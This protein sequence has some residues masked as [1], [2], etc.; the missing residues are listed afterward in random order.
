MHTWKRYIDDVLV[1][2]TGSDTEFEEFFNFLNSFHT[3]IK[4]DEPQHN[5]EDNSCEFLDLKISIKDGKIATDL[6]RKDTAKPRA[7]LP[8]SAH[9][10]HITSNIVYSMAFRLIRIC[11]TEE[12]FEKR[13]E[14]LKNDFLIPRQYTSKVIESQFKRIRNLPGNDYLE[15]RKKTLEKKEKK[16][17]ETNRIVAPMDFNPVLPKI[18]EI[19]TKHHKSMIFKKPELKEVFA[20]PPMA[21]MRQPPNIRK[22]ICR[23]ALSQPKRAD[24]LGRKTHKSAPGW[25]K[26][27]QGSTTCCPFALP[28]TQTVVGQVTGYS[29]EIRDPVTCQTQ[30]CVY[31]WKCQKE[32]CK[33]Y[34]RCEYVGL[35]SRPYR[36]RL[37]EHKQYVRSRN[38][39]TPSG[40]HF[41][42]QGHT[43]SHLGG[44][45]LEHVK[46]SDPFVLR[47]REFL[48]IQKFDTFRNGLN[49]EH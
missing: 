30:N 20:E 22:L 48:Y 1:I 17:N 6:Y 41:N 42:Q 12:N 15:R 10:G 14:E 43:L 34:P 35:T 5:S 29:H 38:L 24:R 27:G 33:T 13:L 44:L 37:A 46:S 4:F 9:P 47:A 21:A 8:S 49:G 39:D 16:T 11:S 40:G 26:C 25:K 2:W 36:L 31:Y 32:K 45:V 19:L 18:S 3:T 7:L 23:A 28:S